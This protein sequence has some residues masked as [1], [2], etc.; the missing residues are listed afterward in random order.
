MKTSILTLSLA[1]I[2]FF[3]CKDKAI[4]PQKSVDAFSTT[5]VKEQT[6]SCGFGNRIRPL[7]YHYD[8]TFVIPYVNY[9]R[10]KNTGC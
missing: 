6:G 3:G 7:G 4:K 5:S 9:I 8:L 2:I 1:S 10:D